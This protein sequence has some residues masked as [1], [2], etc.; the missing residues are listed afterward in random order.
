MVR[1]ALHTHQSEI[2]WVYLLE[3][4]AAMA[5]GLLLPIGFLLLSSP[6]MAAL[7][8]PFAFG[9]LLLIEGAALI[10]WAFHV[11]NSTSSR[12]ATQKTTA[13]RRVRT[14]K[15]TFTKLPV[16]P[17]NIRVRLAAEPTCTR[18]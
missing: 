6:V 15:S 16:A 13:G 18:I 14:S 10:S 8:V 5:F 2:W 12:M 11:R 1:A 9:V 7:A 17:A 3:G 4:L